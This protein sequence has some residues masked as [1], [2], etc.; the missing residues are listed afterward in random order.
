MNRLLKPLFAL[1][2]ATLS[3]AHAKESGLG[4]IP[5]PYTDV[6]AKRWAQTE[7]PAPAPSPSAA[8]SLSPTPSP[9]LAL[10][11]W[12][13]P[14]ND[15]YIG[16]EQTAI[17]RAPLKTVEQVF[18][19]VSDFTQL[20]EDLKTS[21]VRE[22]KDNRYTVFSEQ[23]IPVPFVANERDELLYEKDSSKPKEIRYRYQLKSSNHLIANDGMIE[24][25][26]IS[27]TVTSFKEIDFWDAHWGI[28]KTFGINRIWKSCVKGIA[29]SDLA[30]QLR[31]ENP[32]WTY[33]R[34]KEE[35]IEAVD[36]LP[37]EECLKQR[38]PFH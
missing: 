16:I 25:Q 34:V 32:N 7:T 35:S 29:Q 3:T 10:K 8:P 28:A 38:S 30:I 12:T 31:A 33:K 2:L 11:C 18:D 20:F 23:S 13:T 15:T 22:R 36:K 5:S 21:E 1:L 27:P 6:I 14:D 17:I 9:P 19:Q 37:I 26:S 4:G 24:L